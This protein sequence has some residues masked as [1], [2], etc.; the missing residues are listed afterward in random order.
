MYWACD[1]EAKARLSPEETEKWLQLK[2]DDA[3][4]DRN[5]LM[6]KGISKNP[7]Q[8]PSKN[9]QREINV[10]NEIHHCRRGSN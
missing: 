8:T 7:H 10:F 3:D 4:P 6:Q 2:G 9:I 1:D 5:K